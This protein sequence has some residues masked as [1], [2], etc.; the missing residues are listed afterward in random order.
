MVKQAGLDFFWKVIFPSADNHVLDPTRYV[1]VAP[2]MH[3]NKV[4][5]VKPAFCIEGLGAC[6]WHVEINQH[7]LLPPGLNSSGRA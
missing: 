2:A 6:L 1:D 4:T 5:R 3:H 7:R